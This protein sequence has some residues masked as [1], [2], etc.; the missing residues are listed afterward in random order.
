MVSW[1]MPKVDTFLREL[2]LASGARLKRQFGRVRTISY[3]KGSVT[4]LV[5]N[6]DRE[7]EDY[8]KRSIR[9][10]FPGD[11]ILA[12]ES[13]VELTGGLRKWVIDPVDGTTNFAHSLPLFC[14]S[15]GVE[16]EGKVVAGAVYNPVSE[17]LFLANLGRG[18]TLNGRRIRVSG[19][20]SLSRSL[21][22]TGVP[23]D[24][25]DHPERSLPFFNGVIQ[26]AQ[27]LRRLGSAALDLCFVAMGRF[28]GFFEV[29]LNP[30]DT[31]A[32]TLILQEAGGTITN[33]EGQPF[34]IYERQLAAS[35]GRIQKEMLQVLA[36]IKQRQAVEVGG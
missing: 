20:R 10:K 28:D 21:L 32:G 18:A 6:V 36:Q 15:I 13:P 11:G 7:I 25:H 8:I 16:E 2:I 1:S 5:T 23:Y 30:W 14:I 27:G 35:N 29:H 31:A 22:A 34:S 12:E 33:F 9:R 26:R 3:K 24:V 4:N 19:A 17:E